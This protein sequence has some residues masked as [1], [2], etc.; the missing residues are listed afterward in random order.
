MKKLLF[1]SL[2]FLFGCK[3]EPDFYIDGKPY[4][5]RTYCVKSHTVSDFGYHYGYNPF[6]GKYEYHVGQY[7][8]TICDEYK[9]D[10]IAIK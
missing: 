4:Y 5:T 10:T 8:K 9:T 7:T 2:V 1:L 3:R 6:R